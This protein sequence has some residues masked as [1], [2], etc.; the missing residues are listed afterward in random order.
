LQT[1]AVL[2]PEPTFDELFTPACLSEL[3][4]LGRGV[5]IRS[6]SLAGL[7]AHPQVGDVSVVVSSW[8][9]PRLSTDLLAHCP[10]LKLVAHCAGTLRSILD[11]ALLVAGVRA[12]NSAAAN[13]VPVAEFLLSWVLRWNKRLPYWERAYTAPEFFDTRRDERVARIGNR[14]KTVGIVSASRVGRRLADL[15]R[16]FELSVLIFDPYTSAERI[17]EMG[18]TKVDLDTLFERSDIVSINT[19]LLPETVHLIGAQQLASMPDD[20]LLINT[21][22]GG[23]LDHDALL[24][25]VGCGRLSAVLDVTEPEPLPAGSPFYTLPNVHLTPHVAGSLGSEV[26][27]LAESAVDEIARFVDDGRLL[28]EV[29]VANWE[30]SA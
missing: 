8:G 22:R 14:E 10:D 5:P 16:H 23:V 6:D 17:A 29:T 1:L 25:E 21:A 27:R 20:S 24:A 15:L 4:R 18:A 30:L 28:H 12:T 2:M 3:A 11:P 19:P 26:H 9:T 13:A 7:K